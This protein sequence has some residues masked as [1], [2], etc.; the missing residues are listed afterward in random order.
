MHSTI[1]CVDDDFSILKS[2]GG[3][4]KRNFGKAY[5]IELADSGDNALLLCDELTREGK[6]IALVISD[7]MMRG[8][9]GD[10]FL[11][12]LHARYPKTLKIMLTGHADADSVGNVVNAAALYRYI[13]KPWDETDLLLTISEA[14]RCFEQEQT[15][16]RQN[17]LLKETN[18]KLESALALLRATLEATADGILVL[19][20][21]GNVVSFNE[22]FL[23]IWELPAST[24]GTDDQ[25]LIHA[26]MSAVTEADAIALKAVLKQS[27]TK[28]KACLKLENGKILEYQLQP[29]QLTGKV[30]GMVWSFRDVTEEKLSEATIR[31]QAS[32]D[33]LTN[34][35]N[36]FY[37][38]QAFE[39]ALQTSTVDTKSMAVMFLDLDRFKAVNDQ[40]G[41]AI[42]DQLLQNIAQRLSGCLREQD[43]IARWGGDEFV[44]LLPEM[45][46]KDDV[47][48]IAS[49]LIDVCQPE[50]CLNE[51][52]LSITASIGIAVYPED[53]LDIHTLIHNADTA[54]YQSKRSGRNNYQYYALSSLA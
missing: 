54:L 21:F 8:M 47:S 14:L 18:L 51:T 44:I 25:E 13:R 50:F 26:V 5:D 46:G 22:K 2:L 1:I 39:V 41:H 32:H 52:C 19:D 20:S 38:E 6:E 27:D 34:L 49:R 12:Q 30:V 9:T 11:I 36:R 7:Q 10:R 17:E 35:P 37:F 15:V 16:A 45:R 40:F 53:G 48:E 24:V 4:L 3:Q 23:D 29:Q 43:V 42:G 31:H 33:R 28:Q